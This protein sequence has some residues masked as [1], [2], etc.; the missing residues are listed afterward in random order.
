MPEKYEPVRKPLP[1]TQKEFCAA[2]NMHPATFKKM[3][4]LAGFDFAKISGM[5]LYSPKVAREIY[6]LLGPPITDYKRQ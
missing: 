4:K 5:R 2:Y 6:N 3:L 1:L